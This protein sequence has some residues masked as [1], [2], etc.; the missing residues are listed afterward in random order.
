MIV[1]SAPVPLEVQG[2]ELAARDQRLAEIE[3]LQP[4][5][6]FTAAGF[7]GGAAIEQGLDALTPDFQAL[8]TVELTG[9]KLIVGNSLHARM[10]EPEGRFVSPAVSPSPGRNPGRRCARPG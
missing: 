2:R 1:R 5:L 4:A 9:I 3:T 7:P 8:I 10:L 6:E